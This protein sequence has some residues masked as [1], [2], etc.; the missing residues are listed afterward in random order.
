MKRWGKL[1]PVRLDEKELK[2]DLGFDKFIFVGSSTDIF[3]NNIPND[4]IDEVLFHCNSY[5]NHYL[6]QTKNVEKFL[7]FANS[8]ENEDVICTTLETNRSYPEIMMNSPSIES[9][10]NAMS[11]INWI[12]KF[13]TIE[14]IMDFDLIPFVELIKR[15]EPEQVNIGADSGGHKLQ[16]PSKDKILMLIDELNKFTKVENKRNIGRLLK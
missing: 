15:C 11:K 16:E 10:V 8:I 1:K 9:R 7:H 5:M 4:W 14:P 3:A 13:I 6:F 12:R 2:C